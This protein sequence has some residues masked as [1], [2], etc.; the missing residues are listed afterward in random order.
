MHLRTLSQTV[1]RLL[2]PAVPARWEVVVVRGSLSKMAD[3]SSSRMSR[4][5]CPDNSV[6][7]LK[8]IEPVGEVVCRWT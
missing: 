1:A 2:S 4:Y 5:P 7:G 8:G 6:V 3:L